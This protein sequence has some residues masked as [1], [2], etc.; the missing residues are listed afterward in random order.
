MRAQVDGAY[1]GGIYVKVGV[2]LGGTLDR[3]GW[4]MKLGHLIVVQCQ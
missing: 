3:I 1:E 4:E 2:T